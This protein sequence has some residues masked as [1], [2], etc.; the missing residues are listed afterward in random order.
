MASIST[1]FSVIIQTNDY[2]VVFSRED[3]KSVRL[4]LNDKEIIVLNNTEL[5]SLMKN[6]NELNC[7]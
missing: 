5:Y 2:K 4:S 6:L 3:D 7:Y 1:I